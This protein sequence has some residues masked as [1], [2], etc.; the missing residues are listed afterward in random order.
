MFKFKRVCDAR[1]L[2]AITPECNCKCE[3]VNHGVML[4]HDKST[5]D[6]ENSNNAPF[7]DKSENNI[8]SDIHEKVERNKS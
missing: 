5:N 2:F 8:N 3:G 7:P 4:N 6:N 1:C